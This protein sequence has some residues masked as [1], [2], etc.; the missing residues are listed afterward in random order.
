M[1]KHKT[2]MQRKEDVQR[3]WHQVDVKGRVLGQAAT[4]I[5]Q[6]LI[7]K[8]KPTYTPHVDAGDCVVVTNAKLVELTRKKADK[9]VYRWYT[10]HPGGLK[11]IS[12]KEMLST[13]PDRVIRRAVK[14]ML[15]DNKFRKPRLSRLKVYAGEEHPHQS[16]IKEN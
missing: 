9:K 10:G 12:F 14:G 8:N 15:P 11:E 6:L 3:E 13:K 16:Q 5:A 4:E 2:F 1:K 7:G